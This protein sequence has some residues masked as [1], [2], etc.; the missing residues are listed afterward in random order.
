MIYEQ[1]IG[2]LANQFNWLLPILDRSRVDYAVAHNLAMRGVDQIDIAAIIL[3]GS[4][5]AAERG[6]DYA[7]RT[8]MAAIRR[9]H[10]N[11]FYP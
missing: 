7:I 9:P 4:S 6:S 5:K 11:G 2:E 8:A 3:Y 10:S 1:V